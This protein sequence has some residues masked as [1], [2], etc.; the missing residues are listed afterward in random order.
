M[1]LAFVAFG[2]LKPSGSPESLEHLLNI[3]CVFV[4]S[5]QLKPAREIG[6]FGAAVEHAASIGRAR[7]AEAVRERG[8]VGAFL[9]S[10][11]FTSAD[12]SLFPVIFS[13]FE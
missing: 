10:V 13:K 12:F 11:R 7:S 9:P 5:G 2:A 8:E 4:D 1:P 3:Q 6:Q